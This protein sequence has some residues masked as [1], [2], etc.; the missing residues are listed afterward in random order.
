[1]ES[2]HDYLRAHV[3]APAGMTET[4]PYDRRALV[5]NAAVGYTTQMLDGPMPGDRRLASPSGPR[6]GQGQATSTGPRL[7]IMGP[8]GR[9][10]SP[11][12]AREAIARRAAGGGVRRPNTDIQPGMSGPAGDHYSTVGDFL[13]LAT[14]LTSRRLLDS[15]RTAAVLGARY[16]GG[17]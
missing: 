15:A 10:L 8:D 3:F 12:E 2:Y 14:A 6:P 5:Q 7:R 4:V 9:E 11:E 13:K 1:G 16:S 17:N